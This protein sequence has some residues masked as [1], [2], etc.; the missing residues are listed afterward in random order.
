MIYTRQQKKNPSPTPP[1][2]GEGLNMPRR[3][4][5]HLARALPRVLSPLVGEMAAARGGLFR[6]GQ[7]H[8]H[9]PFA[10]HIVIEGTR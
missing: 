10:K 3:Q 2:K 6:A 5:S 1:H 8:R 4:C 7:C 9:Q